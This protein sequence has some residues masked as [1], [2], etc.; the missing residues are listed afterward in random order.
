MALGI[1]GYS[2]I[3]G[4]FATAIVFGLL[5]ASLLTL[6]LVPALYLGLEDV[7]IAVRRKFGREKTD[8]AVDGLGI[9]TAT[10]SESG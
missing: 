1:T 6:F 2:R 3:F 4:P 10:R 8:P 7:T 9:R 5:V